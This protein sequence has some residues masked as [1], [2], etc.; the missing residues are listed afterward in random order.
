MVEIHRLAVACSAVAINSAAAFGSRPNRSSM[1]A[2][3][4]RRSARSVL[5]STLAI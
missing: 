3:S 4:R 5:P 2:M 1:I